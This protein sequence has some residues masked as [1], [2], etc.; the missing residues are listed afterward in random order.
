[1]EYVLK[2][3]GLCKQYK[4]FKALNGLTMN[5]PRGSIYGF[6][7]RNGAGKTTLIRIIC[8]LQLA[9]RGSFELYGQQSFGGK[10]NT[11]R[12]RVG[13][14]VET[15]SIFPDMTAQ[16]NLKHQFRVIGVPSFDKV[17]ELL[18]LVGLADTGKKKAKNFSLGMRQRLGIAIALCGD[19]DFLILDEPINGL[20]PQGIIEVRELI[21]KLNREKNITVLISSHILDE[22]SKLAT[23]YGFIDKGTL[24][25]EMSAQELNDACKKC[26]ALTVSDTAG[27]VRALEALGYAADVGYK[28]FEDGRID[29]YAQPNITQ[30]VH[31]FDKQGCELVTV[32]EHDETLEGFFI[33]LVGGE[34]HD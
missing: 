24:V 30:L 9:T 1:M 34:Q 16:E 5:V 11:A 22:L 19:P 15:P 20:D 6:V 32:R 21:L 2:T 3:N 28:I 18:E 7:G 10:I 31:A 13:A 33:S 12:R 26:V 25:R 4:S 17:G 23:H 29:V 14:V 8:G 27:A